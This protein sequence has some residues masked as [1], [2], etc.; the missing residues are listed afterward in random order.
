MILKNHIMDIASCCPV[1]LNIFII[2]NLAVFDLLNSRNL[3]EV[4]TV[5]KLR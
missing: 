4:N 1:G 3:N 2:V 5:M